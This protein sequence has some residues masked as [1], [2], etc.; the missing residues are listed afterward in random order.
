MYPPS[1]ELLQAVIDFG[2]GGPRM[3]EEDG[4]KYYFVREG[5]EV[6]VYQDRDPEAPKEKYTVPH[7]G[8][9]FNPEWLYNRP[10]KSS[11]R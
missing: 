8:W 10:I 4:H 6:K 2:N 5:K 11:Y 3:F 7:R 1:A 9:P